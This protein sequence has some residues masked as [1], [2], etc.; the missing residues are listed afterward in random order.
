MHLASCPPSKPEWCPSLSSCSLIVNRIMSSSP[1][2]TYAITRY[3]TVQTVTILK[4]KLAAY[5]CPSC[6]RSQTYCVTVFDRDARIACTKHL[7]IAATARLND[8]MRSMH[9]QSDCQKLPST[10][11]Y[12]PQLWYCRRMSGSAYNH[13]DHNAGRRHQA[14]L[15]PGYSRS[16][17]Q[18]CTWMGCI[19]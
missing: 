19:C 2:P 4:N 15:Q 8:A 1:A 18:L 6:L 14:P 17:M 13:H 16:D 12:L 7:P 9:F 10:P 11:N 3:V 5:S